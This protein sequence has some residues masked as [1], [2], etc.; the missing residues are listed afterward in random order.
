MMDLY[1]FDKKSYWGS[2]TSMAEMNLTILT[3]FWIGLSLYS[4]D[5]GFV[6]GVFAFTKIVDYLFW[7]FYT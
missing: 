2:Q 4:K 5:P 1:E 7:R 6:L 3:L